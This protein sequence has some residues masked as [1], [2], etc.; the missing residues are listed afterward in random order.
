MNSHIFYS[1][2]I[3]STGVTRPPESSNHVYFL[4]VGISIAST[5]KF[6]HI[7]SLPSL[8]HTESLSS[9]DDCTDNIRPAQYIKSSICFRNDNGKE[10]TKYKEK[11][12]AV[13]SSHEGSKK[14][15]VTGGADVVGSKMNDYYDVHIKEGNISPPSLQHH[16]HPIQSTK[17]LN[18]E[19][20]IQTQ[21]DNQGED[22]NDMI[23]IVTQPTITTDRRTSQNHKSL[24]MPTHVTSFIN[25]PLLMIM[26]CKRV[27][28][29]T[30][31]QDRFIW[32][33]SSA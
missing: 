24:K 23:Q 16:R 17:K 7:E 9:D 3:P 29:A 8:A 11:P 22:D 14:V 18:H 2:S 21:A 12:F 19:R 5:M 30:S 1:M 27:T 13:L 31:L 6:H 25:K 28:A 15:M 26:I 10:S 4:Q 20:G 32:R 33:L